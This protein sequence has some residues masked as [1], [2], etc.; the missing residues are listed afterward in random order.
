MSKPSKATPAEWPVA[1]KRNKRFKLFLN[2]PPG[3]FKTRVALRLA[4][5]GSFDDPAAAVVDTE[6]GTDWYAGEFAFRVPPHGTLDDASKIAE[7]VFSLIKSPGN[8]KTLI[9]DT[10]SVYYDMLIEQ[11]MELFLKREVTSPGHK[12]DYYVMQPRDYAHINRDAGKLV[13]ALLKCDLNIICICQVKDKWEVSSGSMKVI[14]SV[15]DGW[16]RLPYYFDTIIS[17]EETRK[18]AKNPWKA[19][20]SAKDRSN[21]FKIGEEIPWVNDTDIAEFITRRMG[22]FTFSNQAVSYDPEKRGSASEQNVKKEETQPDKKADNEIVKTE[23]P[24]EPTEHTETESDNA[25]LKK[26]GPVSKET[27]VEIVKEKK[28]AKIVDPA[29]WKKLL[30]KYEVESAKDMTEDQAQELIKDMIRNEIP[31]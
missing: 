10:F 29:V 3:C 20:V 19:L 23:F 27:L 21:S 7:D 31:I 2:G 6:M 11:W 30:E 1:Q 22:D 5:S 9:F 26:S 14:G 12:T 17:I 4:D 15:F 16:K 18:N 28:K 24:E 13:R 8:I 25:E